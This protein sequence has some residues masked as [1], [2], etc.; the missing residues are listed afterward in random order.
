MPGHK[1]SQ[2]APNRE[3]A[4]ILP[5]VTDAERRARAL[6][7][8]SRAI[9]NKAQLTERESDL[10]PVTGAEAIT[11]LGRAA[12]LKNKRAAG[13]PQDLADVHALEA[14]ASRNG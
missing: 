6:A 10:T 7:R 11:L 9:L 13:R 1:I 8:S 2:V 3:K 14:T 4:G 12:L 5:G